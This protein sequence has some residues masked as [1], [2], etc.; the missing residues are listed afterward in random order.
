MSEWS[1]YEDHQ[2]LT[3]S[4]L[5]FATQKRPLNERR[6]SG[7]AMGL[8]IPT[9]APTTTEPAEVPDP[10]EE[11]PATTEEMSGSVEKLQHLIT[12]HAAFYE[13][14][15]NGL[16]GHPHRDRY[17]SAHGQW[18][19]VVNEANND[20][21]ALADIKKLIDGGCYEFA[22]HQI[23]S[24][25]SDVD[26]LKQA[27]TDETDNH[28]VRVAID[29]WLGLYKLGESL[30]GAAPAPTPATTAPTPTDISDDDDNP[31]ADILTD[32]PPD[33]VAP[34]PSPVDEPAGTEDDPPFAPP[35][36]RPWLEET[37]DGIQLNLVDF[38]R[39]IAETTN[40]GVNDF[41]PPNP[42]GYDASD[43]PE[44]PV[45]EWGMNLFRLLTLGTEK[46]QSIIDIDGP[47][48]Q[49]VLR[50]L[51]AQTVLGTLQNLTA[52]AYGRLDEAGAFNEGIVV[53]VNLQATD[54]PDTPAGEKPSTDIFA[55]KDQ[56]KNSLN[57]R[58]RE[59][60]LN[61]WQILAGIKK[62]RVI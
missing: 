30:L 23:I 14:V 58:L 46:P 43:L 6:W 9:K 15:T 51:D 31:S 48:L 33:T 18:V 47:R 37:D 13:K 16:K 41:S 56:Q 39:E 55:G 32:L 20:Q 36:R 21:L 45:V 12:T 42:D 59:S 62:P 40:P 1:S 22:A 60:T 8:D 4:W 34:T 44:W 35:A 24:P 53:K 3:E 26:S 61:R 10:P 57:L 27:A 54:P 19:D 25:L 38:I 28:T 52:E 7:H 11:C 50:T 2:K 29:N 49:E 17:G 5:K